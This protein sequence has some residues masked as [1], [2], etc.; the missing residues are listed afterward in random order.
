MSD[1]DP[2]APP[3][4]IIT[5]NQ[6]NR[7]LRRIKPH[8]RKDA[9]NIW[10]CTSRSLPPVAG[11]AYTPADAYRCWVRNNFLPARS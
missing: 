7:Y 2:Y 10:V 6:G 4:R 1:Y 3:L 5:I 11:L 9:N 8:I